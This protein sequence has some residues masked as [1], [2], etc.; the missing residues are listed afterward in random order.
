MSDHPRD[1]LTWLLGAGAVAV[2]RTAVGLEFRRNEEGLL[3]VV[4]E[5]GPA[6]VLVVVL[7]RTLAE[8]PV[9][10]LALEGVAVDNLGEKPV[11][12]RE[13]ALETGVSRMTVVVEL[14][15][16]MTV[17]I[18][19]LGH[20]GWTEDHHEAAPGEVLEKVPV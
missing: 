9:H 13:E 19:E 3:G 5:E 4:H 20:S 8:V 18:Q 16:E 11:E 17:E 2:V 1:V 6:E 10:T 12:T 15:A 7:A 14:L